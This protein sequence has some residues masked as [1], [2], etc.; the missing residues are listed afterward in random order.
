MLRS[1][2]VC[3]FLKRL[4]IANDSLD[5]VRELCV[6]TRLICVFDE[7]CVALNSV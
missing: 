6:E 4:L 1:R 2:L 7:L 3:L 5:R